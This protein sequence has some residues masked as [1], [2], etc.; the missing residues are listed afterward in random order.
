MVERVDIGLNA[1]KILRIPHVADKPFRE[2]RDRLEQVGED[3]H[4]RLDQ[5]IIRIDDVHVDRPVIRIY[6]SL[7]RVTNVIDAPR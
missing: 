2:L 5:R 7:D 3:L 4:V 1:E 6:H